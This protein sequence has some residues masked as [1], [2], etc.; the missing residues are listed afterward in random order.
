M[1]LIV[2]LRSEM[3]AIHIMRVGEIPCMTEAAWDTITLDRPLRP[4]IFN[5]CLL[6]TPSTI[7]PPRP[8]QSLR[9]FAPHVAH[10]SNVATPAPPFSPHAVEETSKALHITSGTQVE[11]LVR[12]EHRPVA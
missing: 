8:Q 5:A 3:G 11:E 12:R 7:A 9:R 6:G 4:F 2:C 1:L 10:R